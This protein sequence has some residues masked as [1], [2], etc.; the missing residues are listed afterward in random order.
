MAVA[1][2]SVMAINNIDDKSQKLIEK[3]LSHLKITGSKTD[4]IT[5]NGKKNR[6]NLKS[7]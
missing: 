4:F 5:G 1:T 3:N 6:Q 2:Q 7:S